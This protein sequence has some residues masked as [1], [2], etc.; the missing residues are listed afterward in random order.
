MYI[1]YYVNK[2]YY[3]YMYLYPLKKKNTNS[4]GEHIL[5][6]HHDKRVHVLYYTCAM[7]VCMCVCVCV[8]VCVWCVCA[9]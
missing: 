8:C 9:R 3:R 1:S 6:Q 4:V 7:C 2:T 5:Y